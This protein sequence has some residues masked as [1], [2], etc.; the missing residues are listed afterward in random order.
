LGVI[1][2]DSPGAFLSASFLS[3]SEKIR[4]GL[5]LLLLKI[6]P[7]GQFL[8]KY[9][10]RS[11]LT[12]SMGK[13]VFEKI[14]WP[15]L[16]AK[17]GSHAEFVNMA[18]FWARIKKRSARLGY[19]RGGF[20]VLAEQIA[21]KIQGAN[22]KIFLK[23]TIEGARTHGSGWEITASSEGTRRDY[24]FDKVLVTSSS[25]VFAKIF[26][27][28]PEV[29][30][31]RLLSISHLASLNLIL[32]LSEGFMKGTYWLNINERNF[33]FLAVVEHTNFVDKNYYGGDHIL[34]VGNYLPS[35]HEFFTLSKEELLER[36]TPSLRFINKDF[37]PS[38][39]KDSFL[40]TGEI[41]QPVVVQNYSKLMPSFATPLENVF[42]SNMDMVY[43]W[44]RGTNYAI[45]LGE[46]VAKT[47]VSGS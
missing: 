12:L 6:I 47:I 17:F 25:G 11:W 32:V 23:T 19:V 35:D 36:F 10:A 15:L 22:G 16:V 7:N 24:A 20:Q 28:L 4:M 33:P 42:L 43:P 21:K 39:V 44:D 8:E 45:E 13:G 1:P 37:S 31:K 3:A 2:F 18:W 38:W 30:K 27:F 40:F 26:P 41:A 34:Y 5:V 29:Y 46:R 14:W 9:T